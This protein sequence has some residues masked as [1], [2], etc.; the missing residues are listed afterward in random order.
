MAATVNLKQFPQP[1]KQECPQCQK[2]ITIYDPIG[3]EIIVCTG[4]HAYLHFTGS[5]YVVKDHVRA[6][7]YNPVL[8]LGTEGVFRNIAYKVI[9]YLEKK[10][11][12]TEYEWREYMLYSFVEGYAFLA[13]YNGNWILVAGKKHYPIL[14]SVVDNGDDDI[15]VDGQDYR[16]Y[17][18]Y[19]PDITALIGEYDWDALNERLKAS[20][21][22]LPPTMLVKEENIREHCTDY[23]W[24]RYIKADEI[25]TGF[26]IP[27]ENF[28]EKTEVGACELSPYRKRWR[29]MIKVTGILIVIV[30][31]IQI[32]LLI[33][34]P[35]KNLLD[36]S[37]N[38]S[39]QTLS[40]ADSIKNLYSGT[41]EMKSFKTPT[42]VVDNASAPLDIELSS[43][44]DNNWF[45]STIELVNEKDNQ[46]WN[47]TK[48]IEYYHGY[49]D[50]DSWSEGSTNGEALVSSIPA[51]KYHLN[52][53]PYA[54][55]STVNQMNIKVTESEVL[56]RNILV[57]VLLLLI[58]PL[59][60]WYRAY[61]F[62]TNRWANSDYS[63]YKKSTSSEDDD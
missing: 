57:T 29:D 7:Q 19:T 31:V 61:K 46:T 39:Q 25:A 24:G 36:N 13:E 63:P 20:E 40:T 8:P 37:F 51:G 52:V 50:G 23:Y 33:L 15:S 26:N 47:L 30:L 59:Y 11:V 32:L 49:E 48:E 27:L 43:P 35:E 16:L 5:K 3:S 2:Q 58:Y 9:G 28:P 1:Q 22:I 4:C 18:K 17:N 44:V 56:W 54:G 45:E 60:C 55:A 53:Y 38:F 6:I 42:F 12:G 10:E 62:E 41:Y 14:D 34:K 21:F